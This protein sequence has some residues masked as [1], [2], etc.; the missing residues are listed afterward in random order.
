MEVSGW[1]KRG[2][3]M[4]HTKN[5]DISKGKDEDMGCKG[6][7]HKRAILSITHLCFPCFDP[8]N[9]YNNLTR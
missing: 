4:V 2:Q 1:A 9:L 3:S 5:S 6:D 7:N 8:F